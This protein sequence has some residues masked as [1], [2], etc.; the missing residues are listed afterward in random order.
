[1]NEQGKQSYSHIEDSHI[2]NL[3]LDELDDHGSLKQKSRESAEEL[4]VTAQQQ[5]KEKALHISYSSRGAAH[6]L[7]EN[8]K[9]VKRWNG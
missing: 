2:D 3:H 6:H 9:S 8:V 1:M 4:N 7:E 5:D